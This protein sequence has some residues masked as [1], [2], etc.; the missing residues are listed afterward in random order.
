MIGQAVVATFHFVMVLMVHYSLLFVQDM[1]AAYLQIIVH[2]KLGTVVQT[3]P[4][5]FVLDHVQVMEL[6]HLQTRVLVKLVM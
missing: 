5:Q 6:A 3:A 4:H 2:V 1:V